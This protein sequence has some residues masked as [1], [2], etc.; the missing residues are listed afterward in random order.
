[1]QTPRHSPR[2]KASAFTLLETL[3]AMFVFSIAAVGLVEAVNQMGRTTLV[4]RQ[5]AMLQDRMRSILVE[6]S[7][8]L[9]KQPAPT[10]V[11]SEKVLEEDGVTYTLQVA[12]LELQNQDGLPLTNML[13]VTV[14]AAW[15]E[16]TAPQ[17]A[18]A[19]TWVYLPLFRPA[20]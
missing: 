16:G 7:H 2:L 19:S 5:E 1:M 8:L 14:L 10:S 9:W 15:K 12:P 13:S 6:R 11:V 17:E 18:S 4:R 3:L 20:L